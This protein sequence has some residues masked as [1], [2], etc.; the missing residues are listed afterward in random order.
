M[1]VDNLSGVLKLW[2]EVKD[3]INPGGV[4]TL[5]RWYGNIRGYQDPTG[6]G[7]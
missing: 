1:L 5:V 7:S 6:A 3:S 4:D 2:K